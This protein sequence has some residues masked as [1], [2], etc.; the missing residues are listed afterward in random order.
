MI[1]KKIGLIISL[2]ALLFGASLL[3]GWFFYP[4]LSRILA[5]AN[6]VPVL[7]GR[8][9]ESNPRHAAYSLDPEFFK[10][11]YDSVTSNE[12]INK[13]IVSAV[14]PHHLLAGHYLA[15]FF[16]ALRD[17]RPPV[18]VILGPNHPQRGS[19][20]IV[21]SEWNWQ[22]PEG[23][24]DRNQRIIQALTARG[25]AIADEK[26]IATEHTIGAVVPFIK[27]T[28]PNAE[29]V[30]L[31]LKEN[32][33]SATIQ[34]LAQKLKD[35]LPPGS[36]VLASVD[37][38][39]YLPEPVANF[40]DELAANILATANPARLGQIEVDS[41]KSLALLLTYNQLQQAQQFTQFSHSNSASIIGDPTIAETTSHLIG[42][43]AP[44]QPDTAPLITLQFFGDIMLDRNVAKAMGTSGLDYLFAKIQGTENRFFTGTDLFV[45]NLEGPFAPTRVPTT[46]SIAFRFDPALA[47][48]LKKY[49]FT[50]LSLANNHALD[51]GWANIDF[52][53]KTLK[54][55]GI[56]HFGHELRE[57]SEHLLIKSIPGTTEKVAFIGLNTTD[58]S[59]NLA[60][61]STTIHLAQQQTKNIIVF[62]HW[63]NEYQRHSSKPQQDLAH[64]LIDHGVTAVIGAHPH[65]VQEMEVYRK[66]PIFYSLGNFIFDQYFSQET[67]EGLSVGLVLQDGVI[68]KVYAFPLYGVKSQVQLMSGK[69]RDDFLEW[70][71]E[72]G[73]LEGKKFESGRMSL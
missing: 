25:L 54:Q 37:F 26:I 24:L 21:T 55:A 50:T 8:N 60:H 27:H 3:T 49:G 45:A 36:L 46:K 61:V 30:P 42:Y 34:A 23:I 38:S 12:I 44:G 63:G 67:Q 53:E 6:Q 1:H 65:V 4:A 43:F 41:P 7:A 29:L 71:N 62:M 9:S 64:W 28:W 39:H 32:T 15:K 14:V 17:Q 31:I 40:H 19:Y 57:G 10:P 56:A 70:M 51:M 69:R 47:P 22:T 16:H 68:K 73:R 20:P 66:V 35:L 18:V 52:T 59:L 33:P 2:F 5:T 13:P 11:F 58:H 48:Q 72:N